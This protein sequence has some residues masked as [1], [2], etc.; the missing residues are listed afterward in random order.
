MAACYRFVLLCVLLA[1]S[2]SS[3]VC[4]RV[5]ACVL[6]RSACARLICKVSKKIV[7]FSGFRF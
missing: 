2:S 4:V 1:C 5:R 7:I 6:L 3:F